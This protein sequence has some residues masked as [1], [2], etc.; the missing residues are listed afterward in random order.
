MALAM[1]YLLLSVTAEFNARIKSARIVGGEDA[2]EVPWIV[3]LIYSE[4][5]SLWQNHF[6]GGS[7]IDD[8][9]ILTAAHCTI[10]LDPSDLYIFAGVVNFDDTSSGQSR[11][12]LNIY[13]HEQYNDWTLMNDIAL[14]ELQSP[15]E[16]NNT[17]AAIDLANE[18][19]P[20]DND[21]EYTVEGWGATEADGYNFPNSLQVLAGLPHY[22]ITMCSLRLEDISLTKHLCAGGNVGYDACTGDSGGPMWMSVDSTP[23]LYGITSWGE[24]CASDLPGVYTRVSFFRDW[25]ESKTALNLSNPYILSSESDSCD[26]ES[27]NSDCECPESDD[28]NEVESSNTFFT[29]VD[30]VI[31]FIIGIV[32]LGGLCITFFGYI[33]CITRKRKLMIANE[34]NVSKK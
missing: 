12:V 19:D 33:Y 1:F 25:I 22:D 3:P 34:I 16:L 4:S 30:F 7:I 2:K 17:V 26:C 5:G 18:G 9:W 10:D 13:M 29:S 27:A 20:M 32:V 28:S 14:L 21:Q 31:P 11:N 23:L 15:L 24:G 6:C 8:S